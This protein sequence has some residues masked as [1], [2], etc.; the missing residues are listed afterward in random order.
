MLK[1]PFVLQLPWFELLPI[2][3]PSS[4]PKMAR[5]GLDACGGALLQY[6]LLHEIYI[7]LLFVASFVVFPMLGLL[8]AGSGEKSPAESL[9]KR[10]TLL[11][12]SSQD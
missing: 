3:V 6:L 7:D 1:S 4:L 11:G 2:Y 8:K 5:A 10:S 9:N 12:V